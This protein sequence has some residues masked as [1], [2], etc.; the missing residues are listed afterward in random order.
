M[1]NYINAH[2]GHY[3]TNPADYSI[4]LAGI[5]NEINRQTSPA[6]QWIGLSMKQMYLYELR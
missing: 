3:S 1:V 2:G 6:D 5:Q 4:T